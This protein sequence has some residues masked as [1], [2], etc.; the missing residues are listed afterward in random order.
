MTFKYSL[1]LLMLPV[2]VNAQKLGGV[3]DET[4]LAEIGDGNNASVVRTWDNRYEGVK[5]SPF[6]FED[7]KS[8]YV[9]D[10]D[11]KRYNAEL[12]LD[13][14]N[15]QVVAKSKRTTPII[16][17]Q[18]YTD[19]VVLRDQQGSY[20]FVDL[21]NTPGLD[22]GL[23]Q[24]LFHHGDIIFLAKRIK[25]MEKANYQGAYATGNKYDE[26]IDADR[27]YLRQPGGTYDK[28]KLHPKHVAKALNIDKQSVR[29]FEEANAGIEIDTEN[30][31]TAFL[32][33][34]IKK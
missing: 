27:Y 32:N 2:V 26:L 8:G 6:L 33:H 28:I 7:W 23:Y 20:V 25:F 15:G 30:G 13:V 22:D 1:F 34:Y 9:V 4:N 18:H 3:A 11:G 14:Y 21:S 24:V 29:Q 19:S 17:E 10:K 31:V 16:L 5:G 12:K